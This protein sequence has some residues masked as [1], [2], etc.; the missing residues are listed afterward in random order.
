MGRRK[1]GVF[2]NR[3]EA[4]TN[5]FFINLLRHGNGWK[6]TSDKQDVFEGRDCKTGNAEMDGDTVPTRNFR[7]Q[8]PMR[9]LFLRSYASS[10]AHKS[11][12][13]Y[14]VERGSLEQGDEP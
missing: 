3:P 9:E 14:F 7:F 1:Y 8:C 2:T 11:L 5:D 13:T 12:L 10:D 6:A 4:L